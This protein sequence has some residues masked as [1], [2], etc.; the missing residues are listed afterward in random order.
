MLPDIG[1]LLG[2]AKA[3]DPKVWNKGSDQVKLHLYKKADQ[4][5]TIVDSLACRT[6]WIHFEALF[7]KPVVPF[8]VS[9][10][11]P[12][13]SL[14]DIN[15]RVI[16]FIPLHFGKM[17][18]NRNPIEYTLCQYRQHGR[19][20]GVS[21]THPLY[22]DWN[23]VSSWLHKGAKITPAEGKNPSDTEIWALC[24]VLFHLSLNAG[25]L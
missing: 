5:L 6:A 23:I 24:S 16:G 7:R 18:W 13:I 20:V 8:H 21:F 12:I 11:S 2:T 4:T 1:R 14:R 17:I 9:A 3:V 10:S 22:R 19:L 25:I 15:D